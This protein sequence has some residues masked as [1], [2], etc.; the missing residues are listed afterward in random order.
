MN[1]FRKDV[2][3][4]LSISEL[5]AM[6]IEISDNPDLV[7]EEIYFRYHLD[8][9]KFLKS[10]NFYMSDSELY[11]VIQEVFLIVY[12]KIDKLKDSKKFKVWLFQ[13]AKNKMYEFQRKNRR[14]LKIETDFDLIEVDDKKYNINTLMEQLEIEDYIVSFH[15]SLSGDNKIIFALRAFDQKKYKEISEIMGWNLRKVKYQFKKIF[16]KFEKYLRKK[17]FENEK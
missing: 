7:F 12:R 13:I 14:F 4:N 2:Y 1:T 16:V 9:F 17:G 6:F 3:R 11:D 15:N 8:V 10:I 5:I